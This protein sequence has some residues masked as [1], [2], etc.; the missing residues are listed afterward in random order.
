MKRLLLCLPLMACAA[1]EPAA[2]ASP[3]LPDPTGDS[4]NAGQQAALIGADRDK[5]ERTLILQPVRI[6]TPGMAVTM[7]HLPERLNITLDESEKVVRLSC[8]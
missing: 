4:C 1:M 5:L 3:S 8:G 2:P 7:D 6:I